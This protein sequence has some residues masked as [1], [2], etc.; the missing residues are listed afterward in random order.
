[1]EQELFPTREIPL[2]ELA[3]IDEAGRGPLA[4]PVCAAC[5][6]L[7]WDFPLALLGDSKKLTRLQRKV[8]EKAI[9]EKAIWAVA[10]ATHKEIDKLNILQATMLA[11]TRA[12]RKVQEKA[13]VDLVLI[14]GNKVPC[15]ITDVPCKAVVKGDAKI[16][17]VM[18][19]SILAKEAR[20]RFM[21][22]AAKK[23][24]HYGFEIHKGYPTPLHQKM[25]GMYG[26]SPIHRTSFHLKK[27]EG[28]SLF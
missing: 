13:H 16:P 27:E 26:P 8:A 4:G 5:V 21:E 11:M 23:W 12:L 22:C 2:T 9:K 17:Q 25:L 24:P 20:D 28:P 19:A 6:M 3:G 18:A 10:W 1:M 15:Q 14:D 7:P